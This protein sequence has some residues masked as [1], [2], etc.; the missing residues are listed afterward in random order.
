MIRPSRLALG[1]ATICLATAAWPL[2][3]VPREE[4]I[5]VALSDSDAA[6][7][8][9]N[10]AGCHSLDYLTVQPPGKPLAFWRDAVIKMVN[11]Y[12]APIAPGDVEPLATQLHARFGSAAEQRR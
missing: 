12:G 1:A 5:P 11:V 6:P 10:C 8:V 7:I 3:Y 2:G 4:Q 9:A